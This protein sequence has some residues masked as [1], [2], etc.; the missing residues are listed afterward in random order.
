MYKIILSFLL[1]VLFI[2]CKKESKKLIT[3]KKNI[4]KKEI[5]VKPVYNCTKDFVLGKF[6]Y[7]NDSAF[8][9]INSNH[10]SKAIYLNKE[11]Y[12]A[13]KEMYTSAKKK[14][15][16]LIVISGTRNFYE[17]KSI[18]ERKW[19]KYKNLK[20]L[21]RAKKILEYSSM[22]T[23]SRHHWGTDIDLI[24][25]N[26]SYFENGNGK[27]EYEWLIKNANYFGFYQVY[28][29]KENGRTGYNLEKWHWSYLPLA[30]KYLNYYNDSISYKDINGFKGSELAK[31]TKMI[32]EY[33]NGIS[34]K[35]KAF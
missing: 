15:I 10:S 29:N 4:T 20:P 6:N 16:K 22:P 21:E 32:T 27:E 19:N 25:L 26:N 28:T 30:S 1:L 8:I 23:T 12:K 14:G 24:N 31:K 33:V 35:S 13:F 7:K 5:I 17:Q 11:V 34:L 9:R 18:W 3:I 2:S